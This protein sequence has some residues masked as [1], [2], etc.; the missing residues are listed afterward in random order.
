MPITGY[1]DLEVEAEDEKSAIAGFWDKLETTDPRAEPG[2]PDAFDD[3]VWE[4]TEHVTRG[5]VFCGME[6]DVLVEDVKDE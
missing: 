6:N 5:N 2:E 3:I 4:F 1:V